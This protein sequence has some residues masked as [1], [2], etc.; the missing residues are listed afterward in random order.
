MHFKS[1]DA[2]LIMKNHSKSKNI[3]TVFILNL[4]IST[5]FGILMGKFILEVGKL[6]QMGK[7]K[8]MEKELNLYQESINLK[9]TLKMG[10][11]VGLV[12]Y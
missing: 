9:E 6:C 3:E 12:N 11:E 10:K 7:V 4:K 8:K 1:L 2:K 5:F